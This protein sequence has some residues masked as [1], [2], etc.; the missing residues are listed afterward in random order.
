MLFFMSLSVFTITLFPYQDLSLFLQSK[1]NEKLKPNSIAFDFFDVSFLPYISMDLKDIKL[2]FINTP[3]IE[4]KS[5][6]ARPHITDA[7]LMKPS[8]TIIL[9]D[10]FD[11]Q[12]KFY[13]KKREKNL[14]NL[15]WSFKKLNL[16]EIL[17]ITKVPSVIEGFLNGTLKGDY[18]TADSFQG[19]LLIQG[20]QKITFLGSHLQGA[21]FAGTS[22]PNL[23]FSK[24]VVKAKMKTPQIILEDI[25]LGSAGDP[26]ILQGRGQFEFNMQTRQLGKFQSEWK[27]KV[28][29][30]IA[31][32]LFF[33]AL[34]SKYKLPQASS[35]QDVIYQFQLKG[36]NLKRL[37]SLSPLEKF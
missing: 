5:V 11:S 8:G 4:I 26:F 1:I 31:S 7:I 37:P 34:L 10:L 25:K 9:N 2:N 14:Y 28:K 15:T 6:E 35:P 30:S 19:D 17:S 12:Q 27:M 3:P 23:S 21:L 18:S 20:D 24:S 32:Q 33:L 16:K 29:Q 36:A 13:I 22:L